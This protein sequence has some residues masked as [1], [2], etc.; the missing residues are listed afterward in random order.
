[1]E[2]TIY[3]NPRCSKSRQTLDLIRS[4][5][6]EPKIVLYLE[7]VPSESELARILDL[8]DRKPAEIIRQNEADCKAH[9]TN[10]DDLS[11]EAQIAL[12]VQ[13]PKVIERPIVVRGERAIIGRP[14]ELVLDLLD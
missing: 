8:L 9:C 1:M 11:K 4:K 10:I 5:G 7:E 14:P 12:M 2:I 6:F 3:H 13:Y